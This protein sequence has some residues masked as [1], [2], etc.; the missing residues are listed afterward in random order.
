[1]MRVKE[2]VCETRPVV[3]MLMCSLYRACFTPEWLYGGDN[4][5]YC[6]RESS[7]HR[8]SINPLIRVPC[9]VSSNHRVTGAGLSGMHPQRG[10]AVRHAS[11]KGR[12][13]PS[14]IL[15]GAGPVHHAYSKGG[16]VLVAYSKGRG[17]PSCILKGAGLSMM[18]TQRGGAVHHAYSKGRGLSIMHTQRGGAY[19][20]T[21]TISIHIHTHLKTLLTQYLVL[22]SSE[23][24]DQN[25]N[26][27]SSKL[28]PTLCRSHRFHSLKEILLML[29]KAEMLG[30][31]MHTHTHI[32]AR[33]H[34]HT[35]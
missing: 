25:I 8:S 27:F 4:H 18:H 34:T 7:V 28:Y 22:Y 13:C 11:S 20:N 9:T 33:T 30:H 21:E 5:R 6:V 29:F 1:M 23:S 2:N 17:C 15:K 26:Y 19:S 14:C 12:A 35:Q 3:H 32:H 16:P 10:G 31:P 24:F